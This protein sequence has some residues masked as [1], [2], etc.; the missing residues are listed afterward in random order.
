MNIWWIGSNWHMSQTGPKRQGPYGRASGPSVQ[1]GRQPVDIFFC[2]WGALQ[3]PHTQVTLPHTFQ[4]RTSGVIVAL[5]SPQMNSKG[6]DYWVIGETKQKKNNQHLYRV[7][8][9]TTVTR[10]MTGIRLRDS[11]VFVRLHP[12]L[13]FHWFIP[14]TRS[15]YQ[16]E[17][18]APPLV[19]HA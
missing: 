19:E 11:L 1:V 18:V 13:Q 16:W 10:P 6:L 2:K 9:A 7:C 12:Y 4:I 14:T 15:N 17:L 3:Q 5:S 8:R